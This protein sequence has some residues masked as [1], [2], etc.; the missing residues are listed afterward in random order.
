MS[1][2]DHSKVKDWTWREHPKGACIPAGGTA[3]DYSVAGWR[4]ERPVWIEDNCTQCLF[5]F[6]YCPDSAVLVDRE[7][8]K[9][10]G[11]DYVHCKG[12]GICAHECPS[13]AIRMEHEGGE[14]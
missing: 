8:G 6:I 4:T 1:A 7:T 10:N 14:D 12:C 9:V 3:A 11:F 2:W 5:C 13:E